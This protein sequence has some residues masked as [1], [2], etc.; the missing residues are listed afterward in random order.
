MTQQRHGCDCY[1]SGD[2]KGKMN[3]FYLKSISCSVKTLCDIRYQAR[4]ALMV[5]Q[6]TFLYYTENKYSGL[7]TSMAFVTTFFYILIYLFCV[8]FLNFIVGTIC[9]NK[10]RSIDKQKLIIFQ[11][12]KIKNLRCFRVSKDIQSLFS[13]TSKRLFNVIKRY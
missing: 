6:R 3:G 11:V 9:S 1:I 12:K 10:Y 8:Y 4:C 5:Y 13:E 7:K 2:E